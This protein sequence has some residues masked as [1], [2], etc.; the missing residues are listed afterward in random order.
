[1]RSGTQFTQQNVFLPDMFFE[2][3]LCGLHICYL[4][5][6]GKFGFIQ[7][8]K[9]NM[10]LFSKRQIAGATRLFEKMIFPSLADFRAIVSAGSVPGSDVTPKDVKFT[11]V[12]WGCSIL[13]IRG[14]N[15]KHLRI[16]FSK[17]KI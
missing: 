6:M 1:M 3:H 15:D 7:M 5:K 10:K 2:M 12:I 9:D 4:K 13:K 11:E 17:I 8:V 16:F 14:F